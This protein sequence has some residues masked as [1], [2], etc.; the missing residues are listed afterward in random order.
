LLI[1]LLEVSQHGEVNGAT[2]AGLED[3]GRDASIESFDF[4]II[5]EIPAGNGYIAKK[6][7]SELD[8]IGRDH[9]YHFDVLK[10][11]EG[12]CC[13]RTRNEAVLSLVRH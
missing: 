6:V 1:E 4:S 7:G 11:L 12:G 3:V 9:Q 2:K 5:I 13:D 8:I 10:R